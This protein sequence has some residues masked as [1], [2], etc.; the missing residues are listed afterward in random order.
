MACKM[1]DS[2]PDTIEPREVFCYEG[3]SGNRVRV[4]VS[5]DVTH[6]T[7]DMIEGFIALR[8]KEQMPAKRGCYVV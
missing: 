2:I 7:L 5:G 6:D 3:A 4:I 1:S 8:R